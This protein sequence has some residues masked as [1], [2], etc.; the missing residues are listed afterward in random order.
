MYEIRYEKW[1]LLGSWQVLGRSPD[2][3]ET[4]D[5][6]PGALRIYYHTGM[7]YVP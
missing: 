6:S 3:T 5:E 7:P 2:G 1:P 4:V